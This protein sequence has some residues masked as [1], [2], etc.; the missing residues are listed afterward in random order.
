MSGKFNMDDYVDVAERISLFSEKYPDGSLQSWV[1]QVADNDGVIIGWLCEASAYRTPDDQRPGMGHA[2]EPV[3]GKT[4][5]T[6]D[7]EAMNA[8]TSA[9]GR[10]IIAL[11]FQTKKIASANEVRARQGS[12]AGD[13]NSVQANEHRADPAAGRQ[14]GGGHGAQRDAATATGSAHETPGPTK[15]VS[16][17][18]LTRIEN[19]IPH[20]AELRGTDVHAVHDALV[21]DL[22]KPLP[23]LS[24]LE[25]DE[26]IEKMQR[27]QENLEREKVP[28]A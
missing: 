16:K 18:K 22:G 5:F 10:A 13:G 8:E 3:P 15:K 28:F 14:S 23:D 20:L 9:W 26:L 12:A 24:P 17:S 6:K 2:F 21:Q 7:S 1:K 4:P 25:A 27:W 11:G 19:L